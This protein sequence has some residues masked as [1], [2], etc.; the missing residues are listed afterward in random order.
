MGNQNLGTT[1]NR[2]ITADSGLITQKIA[3]DLPNPIATSDYA[4]YYGT[5]SGADIKVVVHTPQDPMPKKLATEQI[6]WCN[7]EIAELDILCAKYGDLSNFQVNK[8]KDCV[9]AK[10]VL[11]EQ[12]ITINEDLAVILNYP[13]T[14]TLGEITSL[15]W[16]MHRDKAPFRPLGSVYPK[17]FTRGSRSIAG[18]MVFTIFH[19]HVF[20]ELMKHHLNYYSTGSSDFDK[21]TYTT[22]LADQLPPL[23]ISLLFANEY[24]A[25]S[26]MGFWGVEFFQEG[27]TFSIEDIYSENLLHY[28]ARDIDPMRLISTREIDGHG[29]SEAWNYTAS[30]LSRNNHLIRRNPFI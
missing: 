27:G 11:A 26:H 30:A 16:S 15:S 9:E 21:H 13:T 2:L 4:K 14:Q 18:T 24:G 25:I 12:I 20:H 3:G 8:Y 7:Q 5:Y 17:G 22:M 28:V 19:Q 6:A 23:D 10:K 29:V 1:A